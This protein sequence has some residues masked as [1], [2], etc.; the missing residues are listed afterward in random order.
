SAELFESLQQGLDDFFCC[1]FREFDLAAR[2]RRALS[3]HAPAHVDAYSRPRDLRLNMLVGESPV[4]L[5][6]VNRIPRIAAC[7]ATV[8]LCGE[9]G[10][11]KELFARAIHYNGDR[12]CR[13]FVP[14]NCSALP[15]HLF[16]NEVFGHAKGAYTDA[17]TREGGLLGEA[18]GGTLFL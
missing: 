8:L 17:S 1:P 13:P 14:V 15:D 7:S 10:V 9:T 11:G 6:A 4:F 18:D 2:L 12:E 16:E 5:E 3:D